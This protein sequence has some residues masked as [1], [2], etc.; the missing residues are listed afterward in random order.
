MPDNETSFMHKHHP[1]SSL[2][3]LL[4]VVLVLMAG[5]LMGQS[6]DL[7]KLAK[8]RMNWDKYKKLAPQRMNQK[9]YA[10]Y[11]VRMNGLYEWFETEPDQSWIE[12]FHF[13]D[14]NGDRIPD[15]IYTGTT[16]Y[17][18]GDQTMLML[19]DSALSYPLT[20]SE[21]GYVQ[22]FVPSDSGI[23]MTL[24]REP[25][26]TEYRVFVKRYFYSYA[27]D[28]A[29]QLWETQYVSTT[30]IP[31]YLHDHEPFELKLPTFLRST[32]EILNETAVDY[33][34]DGEPDGLGNVVAELKPGAPLFRLWQE[35]GNGQNWSFVMLMEAPQ[36]QHLFRLQ[37]NSKVPTGYCGWILSEAIGQ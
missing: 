32:P 9:D 20:F 34:Q 10:M 27:A 13:F 19:G 5:K 12:D 15:G 6:N 21:P 1:S 37:P 36:G 3:L 8:G 29:R 4:A 30:E 23:D 16:Q 25:S 7:P 11:M 31:E 22:R 26:G 33:D 17:F 24:V 35:S 2:K 28:S 14:V 18:K